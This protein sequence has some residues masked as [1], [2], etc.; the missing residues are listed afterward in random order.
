MTTDTTWV[1]SSGGISTNNLSPGVCAF[2][3][4]SNAPPNGASV[5][6]TAICQGLQ[7]PTTFTVFPP[8]GYDH[9]II[10]STHTNYYGLF[11]G[12]A[13]MSMNVYIAPTSVSFYRV[14]IMEVPENA[15]TNTGYWA[16]GSY[17]N[18]FSTNDLRHLSAGAWAPPLGQ[19]NSLPD[20]CGTPAYLGPWVGGGGFIWPIPAKWRVDGDTTTNDVSNWSDQIFSMDPNGTISIT[21]FKQTVTRS[22]NNIVNPAL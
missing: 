12:G 21:K 20:I 17:P 3:A 1:A 14:Q 15:V 13:I 11:V 2:T 8:T 10:T 18:Y 19:D 5:T 7:V 6:V 9:A 16:Y 22:T 4:P